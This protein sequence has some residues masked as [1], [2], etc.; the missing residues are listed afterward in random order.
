MDFYKL[1]DRVP[2]PCDRMENQEWLMKGGRKEMVVGQDAINGYF[3][4]T[5]FVDVPLP[6]GMQFETKIFWGSH[7]R[8]EK[9]YMTWE[10]AE[11]GHQHA[12]QLAKEME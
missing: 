12:I 11:R 4:S 3:V 6:A 7:E 1:V 9:R 10:E 5:I 2:V 8:Y